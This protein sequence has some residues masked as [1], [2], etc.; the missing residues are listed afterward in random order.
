MINNFAITFISIFLEAIPF[1]MVGVII[2]SIIQIFV[3]EELLAGIIPKNKLVGILIASSMG[4]IF[5]VCECAIIPVTRRLI[6]KGLPLYLGITFMLA[7]PIVNPV[8]LISTY[9]AFSQKPEFV[10]L[11]GVLGLS[12]AII[13]GFLISFLIKENQLKEEKHNHGECSCCHCVEHIHSYEGKPESR[14]KKIFSK[15][16][17][18]IE[19]I[20]IELFDVGKFLI[21]GAFLS[22]IMQTAVP[23]N[24]IMPVGNSHLVSIIVMMILAFV[25][26]ICSEADAF[27]ARGFLGSFTNGSILAFLIFGP[28]FDIKQT[29]MMTGAFRRSFVIKLMVLVCII[30]FISSILVNLFFK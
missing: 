13:V 16:S 3:S 22:A 17:E 18:I 6:K 4:I 15:I 25:L 12:T 2:S 8:T 7:A 30:V 10:I 29:L 21:F 26:S 27:I 23:R 9:Y 14:F 24:Y 20:N 1:V 5:P 19:H 28:I 11:R